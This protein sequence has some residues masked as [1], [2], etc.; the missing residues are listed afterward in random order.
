MRAFRRI[1]AGILVIIMMWSGTG[2]K[3]Q[4]DIEDSCFIL[5]MGFEKI[6]D[7]KYLIRYS[8]ADFDGN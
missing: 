8:Y 7:K 4:R 6:N 1:L 2:C 3:K 5:A